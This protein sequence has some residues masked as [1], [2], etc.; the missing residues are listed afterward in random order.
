VIFF[1][2]N[3][4]KFRYLAGNKK[5]VMEKI[6][7]VLLAIVALCW[8]GAILYGMVEAWP[9]GIIGFIAL[10]AFGLLFAKV[11]KD[12][13]KSKEDDYYSENVDK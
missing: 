5:S 3:S 2:E 9:F 10:T 8:L 7:Y 1:I 4:I 13:L 11:V 12:R 6:A